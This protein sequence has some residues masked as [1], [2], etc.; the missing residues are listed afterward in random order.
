MPDSVRTELSY[1]I[2]TAGPSL[3][4]GLAALLCGLALRLYALDKLYQVEGDSLI[5]GGIAK[6]LL[7]H[8]RYALGSTHVY[9]TLI[10]LPGY[11]FVLVGVFRWFGMENY[12]AACWVQIA[13]ELAGCLLLADFARR[14][15][16][17][18]MGWRAAMA[19]LWL[20]CLCPF[21]ASYVAVPMAETPTLFAIALALW[22]A[23]RFR[24]R[25]GWVAA[26]CFASALLLAAMLRPDGALAG[27]ALAPTLLVPLPRIHH[28][29]LAAMVL[30]AAAVLLA[31]FGIWAAR[32]WS[33]F[34]VVEPL[35]PRLAT[36]PGEDPHLGWEA[37]IKSWCLDFS[38][39]YD[40]YWNVPDN[41]LDLS[42]LPERAFDSPAQYQETAALVADYNRTGQYE[43]THAMDARFA[44]LART[45][46]VAHP[47]RTH[48]WL[49]LGRLADMWLRPRLENLPVDLDWWN[50]GR[51]HAET[52]FSWV[53][54]LLNLGYL[55][56]AAAGLRQ[57]PHMW[58]ALAGYM[59]LRSLLLLTVEAPETRYT[60]ECF[61]MLFVL[62]GVALAGQWKEA[63]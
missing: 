58:T 1:R 56:L 47:W 39:T 52:V 13:L 54:G 53:W 10:R 63:R 45:R 27:V 30:V 49:P 44:V 26:L 35:A 22:S 29:K 9:S 43:I 20:G 15:A 55:A 12:M 31:P 18:G 33:V 16:P 36:D 2:R 50:Y 28:G 11:P 34:H 24:Q 41:A 60:L 38:S 32:N 57:R 25:P 8:A 3:A 6:N 48:L 46:A 61:P 21:T 14:V 23:A 62:G 5:Y 51:H 42:K 19:T 4:C 59:A 37:W 7:L 17:V 40:I